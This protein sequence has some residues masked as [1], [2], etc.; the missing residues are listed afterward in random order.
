LGISISLYLSVLKA[1]L[2]DLF[3]RENSDTIKGPI[4]IPK[5]NDT[6]IFSLA[7]TIPVPQYKYLRLI[8]KIAI[9]TILNIDNTL[10]L[11]IK[12]KKM[13]PNMNNVGAKDLM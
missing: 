12:D 6:V 2:F 3:K 5:K 13:A 11:L 1:N 8:N 4:V 10:A 7:G 9:G